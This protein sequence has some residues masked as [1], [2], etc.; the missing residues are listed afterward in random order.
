MTFLCIYNKPYSTVSK[1]IPGLWT[2]LRR[3]G[4]IAVSCGGGI[5]SSGGRRGS[6]GSSGGKAW[7]DAIDDGPD[8][9]KPLPL[10]YTESTND[11]IL[12]SDDFDFDNLPHDIWRWSYL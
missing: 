10:E 4:G 9:S 11:S 7:S 6:G 8:I 2:E 1:T 12:A 5:A 3:C